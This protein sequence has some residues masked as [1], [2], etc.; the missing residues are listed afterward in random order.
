MAKGPS[1]RASGNAQPPVTTEPS[2]GNVAP[3]G[4]SQSRGNFGLRLLE[5]QEKAKLFARHEKFLRY[6]YDIQP[7]V[8]LHFQ[9]PETRTIEGGEATLYQRMFMAGLRLSFPD[10]T[11]ELSIFLG[12]APSQIIPNTLRYLFASFISWRNMLGTRMS[13]EQFF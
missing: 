8:S 1:S 5:S 2:V 9:N 13:I 6:N 11:Q 7:S 4:K 10:I 12:V 3:P